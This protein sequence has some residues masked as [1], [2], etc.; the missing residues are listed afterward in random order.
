MIDRSR[1]VT[2]NSAVN[3]NLQKL[4]YQN[5]NPTIRDLSY[6]N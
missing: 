5:H 1:I 3:G 2:T 6:R 4:S